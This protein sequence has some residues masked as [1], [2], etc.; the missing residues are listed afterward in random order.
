MKKIRE[1]GPACVCVC[2]CVCVRVC[3]C[4]CVCVCVMCVSVWCGVRTH[5]LAMVRSDLFALCCR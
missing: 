1:G 5:A 2:V 3:V 4:V